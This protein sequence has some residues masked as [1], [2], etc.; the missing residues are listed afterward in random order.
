MPSPEAA[1]EQALVITVPA[2]E[3]L[4]AR[5]RSQHDPTAALGMP[6]HITINYPFLPERTISPEVIVTLAELCARTPSF[7]FRLTEVRRFPTVL[8]LA[9]DPAATF[10]QLIAAVA[11]RF[12]D[13]PPYGGRF[14]QIVP[15][16]TVAQIDDRSALDRVAREF[17]DA[18]HAHLPVTCRATEVTLL[19]NPPGLWETRE[20]F[21][22]KKERSAAG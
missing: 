20:V 8:Y 22:L 12:P 1:H 6:A 3:P 19:H 18:V 4:V 11:S 17:Q 13:S 7:T 2:V 16:L 15:H 10:E 9:P 21:A 5:I 14:P